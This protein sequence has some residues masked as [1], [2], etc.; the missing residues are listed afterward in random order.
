MVFKSEQ[1]LIVSVLKA[2]QILYEWCEQ[3]S[4]LLWDYK[5]SLKLISVIVLVVR[6]WLGKTNN[7]E[8][9]IFY[10]YYF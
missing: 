1:M 7:K 3:Y 6:K 9:R 2:S 4:L 10:D 5:E 8:L